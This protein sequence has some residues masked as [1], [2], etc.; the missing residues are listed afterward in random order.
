MSLSD[1]KIIDA[2]L[3]TPNPRHSLL[4]LTTSGVG[5]L[6]LSSLSLP[7]SLFPPLPTSAFL[8]CPTFLFSFSSFLPSFFLPSLLPYLLP[9]LSSSQSPGSLS[10]FSALLYLFTL[11][12][13]SPSPP[14]PVPLPPCSL[15]PL[16]PPPSSFLP[17]SSVD[18]IAHIIEL[19][20]VIPRHFALSGKYS[21][22]FFNRRGSTRESSG[23]TETH[24]H[25]STHSDSDRQTDMNIDTVEWELYKQ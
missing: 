2:C 1:S 10:S 16:P 6:T 9:S 19:L 22:E 21:R 25:P 18:H 8:T 20:G 3:S 14:F 15:S 12:S 7:L 4:H 17:L 11:F 23:G 13:L 24:R 5:S